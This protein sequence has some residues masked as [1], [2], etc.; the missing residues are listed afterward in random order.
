[1]A[2][3]L[4][5]GQEIE[6]TNINR[7]SAEKIW[8]GAPRSTKSGVGPGLEFRGTRIRGWIRS[9]VMYVCMEE[10]L[11]TTTGL[12]DDILGSFT[13][14]HPKNWFLGG[15]LGGYVFFVPVFF[16]VAANGFAN[17]LSP[18]LRTTVELWRRAG[19]WVMG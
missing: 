12:Q 7:H 4:C 15:M 2:C 13:P 18:W 16:C 11:H 1:M 6:C 17:T 19:R 10:Y 8:D 9:G 3:C 14:A 5:A